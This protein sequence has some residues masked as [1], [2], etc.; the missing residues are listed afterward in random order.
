MFILATE[1]R[2]LLADE[3]PVIRLYLLTLYC[4]TIIL[5]FCRIISLSSE[6]CAV[7]PAL[8]SAV[9]RFC[10]RYKISNSSV[11]QGT[12]IS[13]SQCSGCTLV[14]TPVRLNPLNPLSIRIPDPINGIDGTRTP[15]KHGYR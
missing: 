4:T 1:D 3:F 13:G 15:V 6:R 2:T 5:C 11:L 8:S 9:E 10:L 7:L 14:C 12:V